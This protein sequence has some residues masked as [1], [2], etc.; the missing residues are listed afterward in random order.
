MRR[1]GK[2]S[3]AKNREDKRT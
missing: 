3:E 2:R 1:E